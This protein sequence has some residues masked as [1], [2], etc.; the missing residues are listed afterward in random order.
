MC[1]FGFGSVGEECLDYCYIVKC[2]VKCS[3]CK[4]SINEKLVVIVIKY[5][6]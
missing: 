5:F 3:F 4:R 2:E 1:L 6:V